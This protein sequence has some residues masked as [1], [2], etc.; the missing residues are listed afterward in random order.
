M[1]DRTLVDDTD[2][3]S[4]SDRGGAFGEEVEE[5]LRERWPL[6]DASGS[7]ERDEKGTTARLKKSVSL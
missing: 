4:W 2:I 6:M 1:C 3:T 7:E 5:V